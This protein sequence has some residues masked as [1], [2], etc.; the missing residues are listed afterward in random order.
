MHLYLQILCPTKILNE[1]TSG[2]WLIV[3]SVA[4]DGK[5]SVHS[6]FVR[7]NPPK[8]RPRPRPRRVLNKAAGG[9]CCFCLRESLLA[10]RF[11]SRDS[12]RDR[13][14]DFELFL[15]SPIRKGQIFCLSLSHVQARSSG[16]IRARHN[17]ITP[18]RV[19]QGLQT[20]SRPS[21]SLQLPTPAETP[22]SARNRAECTAWE[23]GVPIDPAWPCPAQVF[24]FPEHLIFDS[25]TASTL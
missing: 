3:A 8:W 23:P 16:N 1:S 14:C 15:K 2:S 13:N 20:T 11:C 12:G 10:C 5:R 24:P 19:W 4:N 25:G 6:S 21:R 17:L 18:D 9:D 7:A 22:G